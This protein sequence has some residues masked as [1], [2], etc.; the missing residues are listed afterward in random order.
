MCQDYDL[1]VC[2]MSKKRKYT[3]FAP[4]RYQ[5]AIGEVYIIL[6]IA[7]FLVNTKLLTKITIHGNKTL[8]C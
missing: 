8:F 3:L 7:F 2:A 4:L 5:C 1:T 6:T